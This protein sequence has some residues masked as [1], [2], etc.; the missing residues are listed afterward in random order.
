MNERIGPTILPNSK[1]NRFI[2]AVQAVSTVRLICLGFITYGLLTVVFS[3]LFYVLGLP[4]PLVLDN[5]RP[6]TDF[7]EIIYFNFIT[8]LTVGYGDFHPVGIGRLLAVLEALVGTGLFGLILGIVMIKI[9]KAS[10]SSVVF[11]R[12]GYYSLDD[13]TFFVV[14]VNTTGAPLVNVLFSSILKIGRQNHVHPPLS[15][16][17]IGESVWDLYLHEFPSD[18]IKDATFYDDDGLKFGLSG[19]TGFATFATAIKYTPDNILV[20]QNSSVFAN[21]PLTMK[22]ELGSPKFDVLLHYHPEGARTFRDYAA[23]LKGSSQT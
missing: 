21:N 3:G 5:T 17:Y 10:D 7:L 20:V 14:F 19:N 16:P 11:S 1:T 13:Q 8:I 9:T 23:E 6:V 12:Y 22:P 18:L 4:K 2:R 15:A